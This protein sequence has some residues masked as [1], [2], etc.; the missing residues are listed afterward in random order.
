MIYRI[1]FPD[2]TYNTIVA[3]QA[4]VDAVYP[5]Q[6]EP[7]VEPASAPPDEP[8]ADEPLEVPQ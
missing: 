6:W 8:T 4:F 3:D 2:G 7:V 5:G 1:Q